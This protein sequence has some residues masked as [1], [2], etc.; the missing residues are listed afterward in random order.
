MDKI[1]LHKIRKSKPVPK[2]Q[3]IRVDSDV[4]NTL[5]E[6]SDATGIAVWKVASILLN[7]AIENTVIMEDDENEN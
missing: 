6:M 5:L 7:A 4:Y 2:S 3:V 1:V